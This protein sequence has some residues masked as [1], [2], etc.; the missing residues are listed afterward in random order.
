MTTLYFLCVNLGWACM[1]NRVLQACGLNLSG[2]FSFLFLDSLSFCLL[3]LLL[4]SSSSS[5]FSLFFLLLRFSGDRGSQRP[6]PPRQRPAF[7]SSARH[8]PLS[9]L[10]SLRTF[11][12]LPHDFL[13]PSFSSSSLFPLSIPC[14]SH[15]LPSFPHV[16]LPLLL[17]LTH[18]HTSP[19]DSINT[20]PLPPSPPPRPLSPPPPPPLQ[21]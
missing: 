11:V 10:L 5:L 8:P 17:L 21:T 3:L 13:S 15:P 16:C 1:N 4:V 20:N 18:I 19:P 2:L 9:S 6:R 12:S 14:T 7:H